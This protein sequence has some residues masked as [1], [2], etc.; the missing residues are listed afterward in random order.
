MELIARNFCV[1]EALSIPLLHATW[2]RATHPLAR[3]VLGRIVRDEAAHG[4]FGWTFLDWVL[5]LL[6]AGG[7]QLI[8]ETA[9]AA[10][11]QVEQMWATLPDNQ[12]Q[13]REANALG[14]MQSSD[15]L[16]AAQKAMRARVLR[17]FAARGL[18]LDAH[19]R[20][21]TPVQGVDL[22]GAALSTSQ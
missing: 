13:L 4:I 15:Y 1:G 19:A 11:V 22:P 8:C 5:P 12:T 3:A 10:I 21:L 16:N 7:R 18:R 20:F 14:W 9:D 2:M 17:P 6:D